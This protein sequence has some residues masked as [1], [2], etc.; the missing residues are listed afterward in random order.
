ML[1][2][3]SQRESQLLFSHAFHWEN[4]RKKW[5]QRWWG[6]SSFGKWN[7]V[8][9]YI[10]LFGLSHFILG[11]ATER[12]AGVLFADRVHRS[13]LPLFLA[14]F[15]RQETANKSVHESNLYTSWR[16]SVIKCVEHLLHQT[17]ETERTCAKRNRGGWVRERSRPK[18][19]T[20]TGNVLFSI[21]KIAS[22]PLLETSEEKRRKIWC[23]CCF[24]RAWCSG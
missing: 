17:Q 7:S 13:S 19:C 1:G 22:F 10:L 16:H 9:H 21:K 14:P 23:L 4:E 18:K 3:F 2:T 12:L 11:V 20:P 24:V 5:G 8:R 6:G 15:V